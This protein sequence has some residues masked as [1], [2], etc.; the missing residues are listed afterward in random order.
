MCL[1]YT[2]LSSFYLQWDYLAAFYI[3]SEKKLSLYLT[4]ISLHRQKN[5]LAEEL[6]FFL[7]YFSWTLISWR[8]NTVG[9]KKKTVKAGLG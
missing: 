4:K 9:Q 8:L 1:L 5:Y 2:I 6:L 3:N 7:M